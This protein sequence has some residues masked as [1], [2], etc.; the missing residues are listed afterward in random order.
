M[1]KKL[2]QIAMATALVMGG[3]MSAHAADDAQINFIGHISKATC[4]VK[5]GGTGTI[6]L[7]SWLPGDFTNETT[8]L[9]TKPVVVSVDG[10][11]GANIATGKEMKLEAQSPDLS[12]ALSQKNLWGN[13]ASATTGVGV[14]LTYTSAV[15]TN[16][17][18][19]TP[20]NNLINIMAAAGASG[21][22]PATLDIKPVTIHASLR[23]YVP[24]ASVKEGDIS[25]AVI[26]NAVY[27]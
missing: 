13:E 27:K 12:M 26:F 8:L 19:L 9:G 14:D 18:P 16:N 2:T 1:N 17:T 22:A 6:D 11:S 4:D 3:A 21:E 25:A 20:N 23:S 7:G 10:C 15:E 5:V 24:S